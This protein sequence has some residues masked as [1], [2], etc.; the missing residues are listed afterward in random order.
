MHDIAYDAIHD[1]IVVGS[2]FAQAIMTFRGGASGEEPPLRMIQ[3]P[4]TQIVTA[5]NGVDKV[6]GIDPVNNEI[7]Y[8]TRE[9]KVLV[10]DR[11]ANGDVPPKRVLNG[12]ATV[13][14]GSTIRIDPVNNLLIVAGGGGVWIFDRTVSGDAK[15][16]AQIRGE[17]GNQFALYNDLIVSP[18]ED[19][20]IYAWDINQTGDNV[21]PVLRI[22][23]PLGERAHQ[24]GLVLDPAHQEVILGSGAGNQVRVFS[25]P[26]IF[27][28]GRAQS[29]GRQ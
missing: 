7:Y 24:L 10:F 5:S 15:P 14:F 18:R 25:V 26:E 4:R 3:G 11:E 1:E 22:P 19:N 9:N 23:A 17:F 29:A 2:P 13:R 28:R 12:S 27:E 21:K 8:S 6:G 20:H 16:R